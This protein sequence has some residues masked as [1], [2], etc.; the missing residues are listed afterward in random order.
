M[1]IT[2]VGI[3]FFW[4]F[5]PFILPLG[6][7]HAQHL[8]MKYTSG[9]QAFYSLED[10]RK[11]TYT[12]ETISLHLNNGSVYTWSL[13]VLRYFNYQEPTSIQE[14]LLELTQELTAHIFP[15]PAR[16]HVTIQY[17]LKD[18]SELRVEV[19]SLSGL[20]VRELHEGTQPPGLHELQ[21][22]VHGL[23]PGTYLC[24]LSTPTASV[25]T[26]VVVQP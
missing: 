21:W 8:H 24:R 22:N 11:L 6:D 3:T 1:K 2:T 23:S 25:T 10:V 14:E 17:E 26:K 12:E 19:Y 9:N 7:V 4:L 18:A 5:S 16:S 15:N 13:E 20:R